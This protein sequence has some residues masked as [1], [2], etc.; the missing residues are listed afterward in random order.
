MARPR[1][2]GSH[3]AAGYGG[4]PETWA[5]LRDGGDSRS[6]AGGSGNAGLTREE[7]I[8]VRTGGQ[9]SNFLGAPDAAITAGSVKQR[10]QHPIAGPDES[11][12]QIFNGREWRHALGIETRRDRN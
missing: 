5:G 4:A 6:V 7:P 9:S 8:H 3:H 1:R 12:L 2:G 10:R 11:A